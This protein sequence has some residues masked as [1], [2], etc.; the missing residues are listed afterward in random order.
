MGSCQ[1]PLHSVPISVMK[2]HL[3]MTGGLLAALTGTS[4]R[5]QPAAVAD[6]A[7]VR[8]VEG[9]SHWLV[10]VGDFASDGNRAFHR[11]AWPTIDSLYVRPGKL[12]VAWINLP[13]DASKNSL[14]AAE[15]AA[16]SGTGMKFWPVHD[17]MLR[18]QP[19]WI[20]LADP[21][22]FLQELAGRNGGNPMLISECLQKR[23]VKAFL[24]SD[25]ARARRRHSCG[26]RVHSRQQGA[27]R[28]ARGRGDSFGHRACP[29]GGTLALP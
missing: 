19:R 15:V 12:R 6:L 14:I 18:E 23:Q 29:P 10:I 3:M 17:A 27:A 13:N 20:S 16:C 11:D 5:A 4:L 9:A 22:E 24:Q 25:V 2:R 28:R 21:T 26:A 1:S 7:R 8:G